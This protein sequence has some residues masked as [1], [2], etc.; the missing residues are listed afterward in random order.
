M[1]G[2]QLAAAWVQA[3][4]LWAAVSVGAGIYFRLRRGRAAR[5]RAEM[6]SRLFSAAVETTQSVL[7]STELLHAAR[8]HAADPRTFSAAADRAWS[9]ALLYEG[10]RSRYRLMRQAA[11]APALPWEE[12]RL[13]SVQAALAGE[14]NRPSLLLNADD[15]ERITV[16]I[17]DFLADLEGKSQNRPSSERAPRVEQPLPD[18]AAKTSWL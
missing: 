6:D 9:A 10:R 15:E 18:R 3:A 7:L 16:K 17:K 2:G 8:E 12:L 1:A 11:E 14:A 4:P 5:L 13:L